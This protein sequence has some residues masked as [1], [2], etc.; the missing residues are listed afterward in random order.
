MSSNAFEIHRVVDLK[1]SKILL[2]MTSVINL[3][4]LVVIVS[5]S[6]ALLYKLLLVTMLCA[7]FVVFLVKYGWLTQIRVAAIHPITQIRYQ[8]D[9]H[10]QLQTYAGTQMVATLQ[11]SSFSGLN[12]VVLIF[13]ISDV[14]WLR[15]RLSL[16]I[17][18]DG[19]DPVSFRH[20]RIHLRLT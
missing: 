20:L 7:N 6:L 5:L 16:V 10:W 17:I 3:L 8:G 15:Q 19:I 11:G 1:A 14:H 18:K 4:A 9:N 13:K 2:W 12:I